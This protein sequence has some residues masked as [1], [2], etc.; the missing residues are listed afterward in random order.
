[1]TET[2]IDVGLNGPNS[3]LTNLQE[4][5]KWYRKFF[6]VGIIGSLGRCGKINLTFIH[7]T[8]FFQN[9]NIEWR[10]VSPRLL[11]LRYL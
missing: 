7:F 8:F 9:R 10:L 11:V 6:N 3:G 2:V 5:F 4:I 1:M